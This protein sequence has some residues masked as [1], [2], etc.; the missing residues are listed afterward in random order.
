MNTEL[1]GVIV[2]F[3]ITVLLAIPLGKY[4]AKVFS[5]RKNFFGFYES[6]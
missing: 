5:G 3:L 1:I 6:A 4:I 2:T